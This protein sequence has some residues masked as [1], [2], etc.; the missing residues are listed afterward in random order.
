MNI[1]VRHIAKLSRLHLNEEEIPKF[2]EEMEKILAMV[3]Q[4][5]PIEGEGTLLDPDHP[6][7]LREDKAQ[8]LYRRDELLANAP[9]VEAGCVVVPKVVD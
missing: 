4:L 7:E 5:P 3:E 6:M 8:T 1:D 9:E 2:T